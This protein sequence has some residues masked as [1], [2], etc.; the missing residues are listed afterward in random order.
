MNMEQDIYVVVCE[1]DTY[2][3]RTDSRPI[4]FEQFIDDKSCSLRERKKF[5]NS[6]GSKYGKKRIAKLVFIDEQ[7]K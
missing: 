3:P 1:R 7:E 2:E 5:V 4:V 6:L